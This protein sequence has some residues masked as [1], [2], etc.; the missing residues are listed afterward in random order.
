M[1]KSLVFLSLGLAMPVL[2]QVSVTEP[3]RV[4]RGRELA[5][6]KE[7]RVWKFQPIPEPMQ[8]APREVRG[9]FLELRCE[10]QEFSEA[11]VILVRDDFRIRSYPAKL[12][13]PDDRKLAGELEEKRRAAMAAGGAGKAYR[14]NYTPY[15]PGDKQANLTESEHFT[16]YYGNERD[17]V[18]QKAFSD[19]E[20]INR[21]KHWYEKT[22]TQLGELKA[23]LPMANDPD[24]KKINIYITGTG[25]PQHREGFAF[26][27]ESVVIHPAALGAGSS[28]V[29]HEFTHS[30]Q[31]YAG[32]YRD[33]PYVGW[34][35][36]CHANWSTHQCM[37]AY[38]P[39]LAHYVNRAHY[40]LNSSRHN[41][42]SWPFLQVLAED[43]RFGSG[44]PY[45]IWSESLRDAKGSATE[46]P[47]QTIMRLGEKRGIWKD[48]IAGFGDTIGE[49]AARMVTWDFQN[50][51]VYQRDMLTALRYSPGHASNRTV[52]E[53]VA[54]RPGWW[55]PIFSHAPRQFGVNLI[56]L[57]PTAGKVEV[58]F[59]GIVD[60]SEGSDWR[61]TLVAHA[62]HGQPRYSTTV[63]G[64]KLAMD[65][66]P[67][68]QLTLAIAATPTRY[69][70]QEFRPGYNKKPRFPYEVAVTGAKPAAAPP[71]LPQPAPAMGAGAPHPNGG[72]FVSVSAKVA[73]TAYVGPNAA[74]LDIA[75]VSGE[76]RIED[77]AVVRNVAKV[78]GQAVVAGYARLTE[79][80]QVG[81]RAKVAGYARVGGKVR[82]DENARVLE[83]ATVEGDG[84]LRGNVL[85]K[86]FGEVM[87]RPETTVGG[88][89]IFGED[90]E[91]HF[92]GL[93]DRPQINGGMFYGY[94]NADFIRKETQDN[95]W[96]Y[97][98]WPFNTPRGQVVADANADCNGVLRGGAK[99]G[100]DGSRRFIAFDGSS[101]VLVE[102]HPMETREATIDMQLWWD[103]GE[104]GQRICE[105]GDSSASVAIGL[106][107]GGRPAFL[108]RR[109]NQSAGVQANVP[110]PTKQWTR[111]TVTV[112][113]N[114]ARIYVN[115]T[116][117]GE[118]AQFPLT[119]E[120]VRA[121]SGRLGAGVAGKGFRGR[122]DD[123]AIFRHVFASIE[124][125]PVL[126]QQP[127]SMKVTS[128]RWS[129]AN[130]TFRRE[131]GPDGTATLNVPGDWS[132]YDLTFQVRRLAGTDGCL[133]RLRT[134]APERR[135]AQF[136]VGFQPGTSMTNNDA[137]TWAGPSN[138][139]L[140]DNQWQKVAIR[141]RG[142]T[143]TVTIDGREALTT[144]RVTDWARGGISLGATNAK[145]EF[146]DVT[147]TSPDGKPLWRPN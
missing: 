17:E 139:P 88:G 36:E 102:G 143:A 113:A 4:A 16:F 126:W 108:I 10:D 131:D 27:G 50:E 47:F 54:D 76:A 92:D 95:N 116:L 120:D 119:P 48:G 91:V 64:G 146:K 89:T 96:L 75:E 60:E 11:A 144:E 115:G 140:A 62:P 61:V 43:P 73:P 107:K 19:P 7:M 128:G 56:D 18:A 83:Y 98:H 28:V 2:A 97:P 9:A 118:N 111:L 87:V 121:T 125:I 24:P 59:S 34:F 132:D 35:W 67:G 138:A 134:D 80:A 105:F 41:Y 78:S 66:K 63:R 1:Q 22:W 136:K 58:D 13:A 70:P 55:K 84:L 127:V 141:L 52:L 21:Q 72:G 51:F 42:G 69:T 117:V 103:G 79:E 53:P 32:G 124:E 114:R 94:L 29:S 23:P 15:Q 135:F 25:L 147:L 49:L 112:G 20:F 33:S 77:H 71:Q 3:L 104:D 39:V 12:L 68:E 14:P 130:G 137:E 40:E 81:G 46:D 106:T 142:T 82:L 109:D 133:V 65:V 74:V 31:F 110:I 129:E 57:E 5:A 122:I 86:G 45:E 8:D 100:S 44:F 99:Y 38:A 123:L 145:L 101:H 26:G 6:G 85:V 37:P 90:L 93:N 30:L